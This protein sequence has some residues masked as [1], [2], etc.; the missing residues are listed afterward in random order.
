[1]DGGGGGGIVWL[2][3][4]V[5]EVH[6]LLEGDI[7]RNGWM[8]VWPGLI[9]TAVNQMFRGLAPILHTNGRE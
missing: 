2:S 3:D 8:G 9:V 5:G 7:G 6:V 1:M 4:W